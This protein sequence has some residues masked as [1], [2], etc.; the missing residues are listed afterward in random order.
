MT[1]LSTSGVSRPFDVR[2]DGFV[3]AE[4]AGVLVLEDWDTGRGPGRHHPGRGARRAPAPPTPTTSP[5]PSPGGAGAI[6]C[7][8]LALADA[9][10]APGRHRPDQRPRHL[11][12]A[13]RRGR[14]RGH[15]QGVRA[16]RARRSPRS[17]ASPATRS[18]PPASL[19]AVAVVQSMLTRD[20]SR[21]PPATASPTPSWP[22]S[23][24]SPRPAP[25]RPGP[26]L[27]N[28]LRLRRP[29]R[30]PG[31]RPRPDGLAPGLGPRAD[32][33]RL[34]QVPAGVR[35]RRRGRRA[36]RPRRPARR[37]PM[38][39][40]WPLPAR[41]DMRPS[42]T[43]S[44]SVSPGPTW[45]RKRAPSTPPNSGSLPAKR[46]SA[47]TAHGPQLG[48]GL[49]HEHPGQ[50]G[51]PGEVPG[52]ERLVAGEAPPALGPHARLELDDLVE[53][54]G[55]A[56]GAAGGRPAPGSVRRHDSARACCSFIG[57]SLGLILYQACGDLA[58][59]VDQEG[60][61]DDAHVGAAVVL[62]LAPHAEGLGHGVLGVG[63]QREAERVLV[64]ELL[65]LGRARRG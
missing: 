23:T 6:A 29:Q 30:L 49:D 2:R 16:A 53:R 64:V 8:E 26:T 46:S 55:T 37:R 13:Q 34:E 24:S 36:G 22:P 54:T 63:Q 50:G 44:S 40:P 18:A 15:R 4:G 58:L 42:S 3:M 7:M 41:A 19:E 31:H 35:P 48:D 17:R 33:R 27:S 12:A 9:G 5:P 28:S 45:R 21:P 59:L 39:Q 25:G 43:S 10:L 1:A 51:P 62:L 14:G 38:A 32:E 56:V 57:V 20:S 11:D 61:A 47:S 52:E 60:R 65:L